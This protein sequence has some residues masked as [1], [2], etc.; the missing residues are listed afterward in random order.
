M[1]AA[2][3]LVLGPPEW[4]AAHQHDIQH[5]ATGPDV[6]AFAV[7]DLRRQHLQAD[8]KVLAL[9]VDRSWGRQTKL[10]TGSHTGRHPAQLLITIMSHS[11][12]SRVI[13]K[14]YRYCCMS[15]QWLS[16]CRM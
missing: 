10:P 11:T 6:R 7:I 14:Q 1:L 12:T 4:K 15:V 13:N 9:A 2:H 5:D 16:V 8:D 3:P